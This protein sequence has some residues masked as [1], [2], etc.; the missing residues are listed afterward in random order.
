MTIT[1]RIGD[2]DFI[3]DQFGHGVGD[4]AVRVVVRPKNWQ[5]G[6][7][8][9]GVIYMTDDDWCAL[10]NTAG[11]LA[12]EKKR[13]ESLR[14][15]FDERDTLKKALREACE[16]ALDERWTSRDPKIREAQKVRI[17][18]LRKVGTP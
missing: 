3:G 16:I 5:P 12:T 18:E 2:L 15:M 8:A 13:V 1:L 4:S 7:S 11:A 6:I 14:H 17:A 9:C 10:A